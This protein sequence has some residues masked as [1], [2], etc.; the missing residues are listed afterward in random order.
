MSERLTPAAFF[1]HGSPMNALD[2]N[3]YTEAWRA[4]GRSVPR[5]RAILVL[6]AHW[7]TDTTLVTAM[8]R[9]RTIHDFSG[10]PPALYAVQY[11]AQ[12]DP[13]LAAEIVEALKTER[14]GLDMQSW[15]I[16]HGAWSVLVH[17]FPSANIPVLQ[18]SLAAN[19]SFGD[20]MRLGENLAPLRS[21]GVL[22]IGSGNVVHNLRRIDL[23]KPD[24]AFDW[25][26][27]F[28]TAAKAI[29]TTKPGDLVQ[30]QNHPDYDLAAPTA[31][32]FIPLLY[33]AGLAS[34]DCEPIEVLVEGFSMGSLSMAAYTLGNQCA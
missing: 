14:I 2:R 23:T 9:P 4:F 5:P 29:L 6:S 28:D 15:G 27:R 22:I 30:L 7:V 26:M 19:A 32:H 33:L 16:D 18:L 25:A 34:V 3:R 1:G 20:H 8:A 21:R 13:E 31:E 10:F 12:G 24:A 11:P 17:A